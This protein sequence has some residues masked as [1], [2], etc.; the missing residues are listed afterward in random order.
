MLYS[1]Q[2]YYRVFTKMAFAAPWYKI[3]IY[4]YSD[5]IIFE[6]WYQN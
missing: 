5:I 2:N 3:I 4:F 6:T 1:L